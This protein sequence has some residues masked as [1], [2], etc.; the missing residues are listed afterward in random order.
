LFFERI[1]A[2]GDL[3]ILLHILRYKVISFFKAT[4]DLKS[5]SIVRGIGSLLVFAGFSVG[6]FYLSRGSTEFVIRQMR[7]GL[8]LFHEFVSMVLFIFFVTVNM[9]NIIVSYAT[10]YRS[11]EVGYLLTKPVSYTSVFVL[12]FLDNFLY[13]STTLFLVAF[14]VICGYGSFFH[15]PWY[16]YP[17]VMFAVLVPFMFLS[18]S[19][20]VLILMAIMK[21]AGKIGFRKVMG[22]LFLLY[23]GLVFLY[24]HSFNPI[25]LVEHINRHF[26]VAETSLSGFEPGFL[27]YLPNQWISAFLYELALGHL[28]MG[29]A[30]VALLLCV[31][32]AAFLLTLI[33]ARKFYYRSW[34]VSLQVQA[35]SSVPYSSSVKRWFDF[36]SNSMVA[37]QTEV[38]LKKE[39]FQFLREPSQW[40]HF[41]V[42]AVLTV[43]FV[44]A[45]GNLNLRLRVTEV[46]LLTYLVMFAF[47]GFLTSSIAL[48]FVFPMVSLEG[49]PF[50][51]LLSSPIDRRKIYGVKFVLGFLAVIV[52]ALVVA[53]A[54]N[55]PFVRISERRPLLM[56]SGI[57]TAFWV[58]VTMVSMNLGFGGFFAN[59]VEKN[60]IR[61]ASSQGATLT[62]LATLLYLIAV[63][64]ILILPIN[65]YFQSIF[66]FREFNPAIIVVPGTIV[67]ML[68][69][70]LTGFSF[71]F[72][73]NSLQRDF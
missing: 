42:M 39:Y 19:V 65:A 47:G 18:A 31:T 36:R 57:F 33:V 26:P 68:S 60:P 17:F 34:L 24:F 41:L 25:G 6:A 11:S 15:Y 62:F 12:K 7:A 59:Y 46:Q 10:L 51:L 67:A 55:I 40:I 50:W 1:S 53:V 20:A 70:A 32:S 21:L 14:M 37:P 56:Y 3:E 69:A 27:K 71:A 35:A 64:T 61:L 30:N 43:V 66:G 73:I 29:L 5:V 58:S 52:L 38:L 44:F 4:F 49:K 45:V 2:Q 23:F 48:R 63:V 9:G 22:I 13:S 72:G 8:F 54:T 16:F 28:W